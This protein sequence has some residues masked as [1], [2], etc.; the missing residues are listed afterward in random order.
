M[1]VDKLEY[2]CKL[3]LNTCK[4]KKQYKYA[5]NKMQGNTLQKYLVLP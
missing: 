4:E 1:L 3:G 5:G 2:I